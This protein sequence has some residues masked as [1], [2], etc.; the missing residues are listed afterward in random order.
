MSQQRNEIM[1]E[2][3]KADLH[4][5]NLFKKLLLAEISELQV[6]SETTHDRDDVLIKGKIAQ[7]RIFIRQMGEG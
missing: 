6:I 7:C 1:A 3:K 2:I 4:T 5:R